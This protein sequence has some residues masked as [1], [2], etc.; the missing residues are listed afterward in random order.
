MGRTA[1]TE[2]QCLYKGAFL[3]IEQIS[4][5]ECVYILYLGRGYKFFITFQLLVK[6]MDETSREEF[7]VFLHAYL[8]EIAKYLRF[9]QS[10]N[11]HELPI[12]CLMK[13]GVK[14]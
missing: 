12:L 10:V 2:P 14:I 13:F 1:S 11:K 9:T 5:A 3:L 4:N 7:H 8:V 6:K